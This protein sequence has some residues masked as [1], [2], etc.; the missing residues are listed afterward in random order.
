MNTKKILLLLLAAV[1]IAGLFVGCSAPSYSG[2]YATD[3]EAAPSDDIYDSGS[4][5]SP[6]VTDRKLI[7]R[8]SMDLQTREIETL[9][10]A[11]DEK[12]AELG[13]Y[14]ESRN[15]RMGS[16][17]DS[18]RSATLT[19]RI[20]ADKLDAFTKHVTSVSNVTATSESAEDIT[21]N[22]VATESKKK[23]LE[24]EEERLLALID[25]AAN[26]TEL[27]QLEKR[28]TEVRTDLEQVTSQLK[29]Y[30]NLVDYGT[31]NLDITEVKEYTPVEEPGFWE[32]ITTGFANSMRNT[33]MILQELL[34]FFVCAIPY[35]TPPAV[36]VIVILLIVLL[37][38]TIRKRKSKALPMA[39]RRCP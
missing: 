14:V 39:Y 19:V 1:M 38:L 27:L 33:G 8:I 12:V 10:A 23:A 34:I 37:V 9:L 4:S 25:K 26:L 28:L 36:V 20:P 5:V 2:G 18:N 16:G 29:V 7:R 11:I 31:V 3:S 22:Y 13:G 35:L 21:L 15:V 32:R 30:D 17:S 24:A 6:A